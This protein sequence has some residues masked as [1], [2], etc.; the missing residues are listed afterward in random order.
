[1]IQLECL[2]LRI[3]ESLPNNKPLDELGLDSL[4]AVELR[5]ALAN[6]VGQ[7]LP[8]TLLF[9]YPTVE[10]LTEYLSR[11]RPW[12]WKNPRTC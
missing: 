3:L 10:T 7:N 5:N 4:M 12:V 11:T 8:A 2:D 1:M 9:D 6:T